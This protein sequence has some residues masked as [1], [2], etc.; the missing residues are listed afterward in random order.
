MSR[1]Q[2]EENKGLSKPRR[3]KFWAHFLEVVGPKISLCCHCQSC[4][5]HWP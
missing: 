2:T 1:V 3:W 5:I 4:H